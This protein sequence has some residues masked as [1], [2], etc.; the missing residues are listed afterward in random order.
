M[1]NE[2]TLRDLW[3]DGV[4]AGLHVVPILS[5]RLS[6]RPE[7]AERNPDFARQEA[8]RIGA[9]LYLAGVRRRFGVNLATNVY[10]PK[11]KD[12]IFAQ[13]GESLDEFDPILLWM[14]MIGG[15]Q[16]FHA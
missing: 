3:D 13:G 9:V 16:F 5:K 8:C 10:T 7:V 2:L 11:P 14:L 15:V 4:F 12:S 6:I 1:A